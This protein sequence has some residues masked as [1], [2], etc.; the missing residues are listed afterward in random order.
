MPSGP[1]PRARGIQA[2]LGHDD[3]RRGSI[4]ASA[5]NPPSPAASGWW[6]RVHP[7]ERGESARAMR[8]LVTSWGPSPRARGILLCDPGP[9]GLE[10][11]IPAS[12]GNP[13]GPISVSALHWVHPRERGESFAGAP[14]SRPVGGPSPRA[15]GILAARARAVHILGSIPA[16]AGNPHR[17]QIHLSLSR[18]H[19]RERG[20]SLGR[21]P[22]RLHETGPSPRARG[23]PRR[24]RRRRRWPRS[25]PASAGNPPRRR[26]SCCGNWVHPRERGE[27]WL[28]FAHSVVHYGP[29]PRARGIPSAAH[30]RRGR[31]G[32]I[33]ASAGNPMIRAAS[34]TTYTV[35]PRERGESV[36]TLRRIGIS[37][38]PSPRARGI[39]LQAAEPR[40]KVGSI[41]ASAGNP[42]SCGMVSA[43]VPVHPRERGES[44]VLPS[45]TAFM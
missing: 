9:L 3:H 10:G 17:H 15:R 8:L 35:H 1:S 12:A 21:R 26:W 29:S 33:P 39:H 31:A 45:S 7:R 4:P 11:S 22:L 37:W 32:S 40:E 19:P 25:I 13:A 38:G 27:S 28:I 44:A 34:R 14:L 30:G 42:A 6:T 16:S 23:I 36:T 5:G 24:G 18:V 20:E 41:P 43:I 2:D